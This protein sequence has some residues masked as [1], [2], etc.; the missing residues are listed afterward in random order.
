MKKEKVLYYAI[1]ENGS[2]DVVE[3]IDGHDKGNYHYS[4]MKAVE[5]DYPKSE[6][7]YVNTQE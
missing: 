1:C 6:W 3:N 7:I 2:I 5:K 4:D